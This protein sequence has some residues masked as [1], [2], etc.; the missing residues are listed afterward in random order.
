MGRM[1]AAASGDPQIVSPLRAVT[2]TTR[3]SNPVPI[4]LRAEGNRGKLYWFANE[5]FLGQANAGEGLAWQPPRAGRFVLRAVDESGR[6]DSR[7][8]NVEAVP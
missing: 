3:I 1:Q 2:Y 5:A 4:S 8:I 7:D 6:A